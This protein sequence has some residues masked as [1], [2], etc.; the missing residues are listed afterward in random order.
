MADKKLTKTDVKKLLE[1]TGFAFE[2]NVAD[3]LKK[4]GYKVFVNR[5]FF[6]LEESKKRE[7]DIIAKKQIGKVTLNFVIECKQSL[8]DTWVFVC[9]DERPARYYRYVKH[10]PTVENLHKTELFN[11]VHVLN[12]KAK[13]SQNYSVFKTHTKKKSESLQIDEATQKL[14]KALLDVAS[15]TLN[16]TKTKNIFVPLVV[17]NG[18]IFSATYNEQLIVSEEDFLYH[19][20][21]FESEAYG[22]TSSTDDELVRAAVKLGSLSADS[23]YDSVR[24][25][26]SR[27]KKCHEKFD[28]SYAI[29]FTN[30]PNLK[31]LIEVYESDAGKTS[32]RKWSIH[33]SKNTSIL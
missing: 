12:A 21:E 3:S 19:A 15:A 27:I 26:I 2:M 10:L 20:R 28:S 4:L 1:K 33:K 29:C 7:I 13:I 30:F 8:Q 23:P 11:H 16:E 25:K 22:S 17:F 14:P 5:Y 32:V 9:S 6:D 18:Q 24:R 31:K